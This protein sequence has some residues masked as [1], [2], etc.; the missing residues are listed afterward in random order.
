M[1]N[2]DNYKDYN[3][4]IDLDVIE[5]EVLDFDPG[6]VI[7]AVSGS[8]YNGTI[9]TTYLEYFNGIIDRLPINTN[10][11][12]YRADQY[13][14]VLCYSDDLE[15]VGGRFRSSAAEYI[16]INTY[17]GTTVTTGNDSVNVSVGTAMVY[18]NI[19][20]YPNSLKG[21]THAESVTFLFVVTL[22][23]LF[24]VIRGLFTQR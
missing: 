20:G 17:N 14:Y 11:L 19:G 12:I 21:V 16:N 9:S 5:S 8:A 23:L 18:S 4:E 13:N 15:A 2:Q 3:E 10:Y 22:M 6:T 1:V 7:R 24:N